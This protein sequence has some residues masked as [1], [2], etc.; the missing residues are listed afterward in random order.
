MSGLML[1]ASMS[2]TKVREQLGHVRNL[3]AHPSSLCRPGMLTRVLWRSMVL[4]T[5]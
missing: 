3:L 2:D 1:K 4:A 5:R